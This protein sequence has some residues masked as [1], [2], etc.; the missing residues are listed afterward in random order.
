MKTYYE[1][2]KKLYLCNQ[3]EKPIKSNQN[4]EALFYRAF[5]DSSPSHGFSTVGVSHQSRSLYFREGDRRHF[6]GP[7]SAGCT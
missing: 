6:L 3:N 1:E 7:A 4:E 2:K 5:I